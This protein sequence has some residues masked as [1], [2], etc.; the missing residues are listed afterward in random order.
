MDETASITVNGEHRRVPKGISV[1]DLALELGLEPT[2]VAVERNLEI[3]PRS[4]LGQVRSRTATITRSSPSSA[5]AEVDPPPGSEGTARARS[6][7][8][9]PAADPAPLEIGRSRSN[10]RST[11]RIGSRAPRLG[12]PFHFVEGGVDRLLASPLRSD[13]RCRLSRPRRQGAPRRGRGRGRPARNPAGRG[14]ARRPTIVRD[15]AFAELRGVDIVGR[16]DALDL[17]ALDS[18]WT[19]MSDCCAAAA[20]GN[21]SARSASRA[22]RRTAF[23]PPAS[24]TAYAA[25]DRDYIAGSSIYR[26][27]PERECRKPNRDADRRR[28]TAGPSPAGPSRRG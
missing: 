20:A 15:L 23:L 2:R 1:A 9:P 13:R 18:P 19:T 10:R 22:S 12:D 11:R 21:G 27:E 7:H 5:A 24:V 16:E 14:R 6:R 8:P 4:T 17:R 28:T 3:V 25:T 26:A